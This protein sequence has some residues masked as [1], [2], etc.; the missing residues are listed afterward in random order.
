MEPFQTPA[1][2]Q[3]GERRRWAIDSFSILGFVAKGWD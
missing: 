2:F 1:T 3:S